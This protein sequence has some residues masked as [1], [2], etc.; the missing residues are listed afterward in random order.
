MESK[1]YTIKLIKLTMNWTGPY[2]YRIFG[3]LK[4]SLSASQ[5]IK[6]E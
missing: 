1:C 6:F 3:L 5:V 4:D 2:E